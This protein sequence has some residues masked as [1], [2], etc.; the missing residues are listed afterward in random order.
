[1]REYSG[2]EPGRDLAIEVKSD[3][4]PFL[5]MLVIVGG[6]AP[7][8]PIFAVWGAATGLVGIVIGIACALAVIGAGL[9]LLGG[10]ERLA[11]TRESVVHTRFFGPFRVARRYGRHEVQH[12]RV[13]IFSFDPWD[14]HIAID[15]PGENTLR[16]GWG[17]PEEELRAMVERLKAA[18]DG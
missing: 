5:A 13:E 16:I 18:L 7:L 2:V 15:L 8:I 1:M 9:W 6:M 10:K 3:G 4:S 12:P 17:Y 11:V 14:P